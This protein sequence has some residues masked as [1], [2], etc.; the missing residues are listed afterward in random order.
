MSAFWRIWLIVWAW[1]VIVFGIVIA[2]GAFEATSGPISFTY[3]T[4]QGGI[5]PTFDPA[6][7]F[8]LAVMGAVSIGWGVTTLMVILAAIKMGDNAQPLWN[9][10]TAGVFSW[11]VIDSFLSVATGFGLN[12]IPNIAL[13][14]GYLIATL[15]TGKLV[16]SAAQRSV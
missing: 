9:A 14:V 10:V 7:R 16:K 3:Q 4:L 2:G 8:S 12:V 13:L 15:A 1:G 5:A 11:F 6:L